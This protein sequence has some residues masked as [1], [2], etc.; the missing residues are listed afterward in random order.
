MS[1]FF[2]AGG[3]DSPDGHQ[4]ESV[5][6]SD[7]GADHDKTGIEVPHNYCL[8]HRYNI[9]TYYCRNRMQA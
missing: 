8:L 3:K 4:K 9:I 6:L 5:V 2:S 1:A 7:G